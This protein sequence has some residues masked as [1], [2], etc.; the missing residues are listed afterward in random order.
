MA[1]LKPNAQWL[2]LGREIQGRDF[3]CPLISQHENSRTL[4]RSFPTALTRGM[5]TLQEGLQTQSLGVF[6]IHL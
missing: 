6:E 1:T 3:L 5:F 2:H 4:L